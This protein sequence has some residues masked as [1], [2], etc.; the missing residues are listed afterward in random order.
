MVGSPAL[1]SK[2]KPMDD[3]ELAKNASIIPFQAAGGRRSMFTEEAIRLSEDISRNILLFLQKAPVHLNTS[4]DVKFLVG[5]IEKCSEDLL[6]LAAEN[7]SMIVKVADVSL[8]A[9]DEVNEVARN[10][11]QDLFVGLS[12]QHRKVLYIK[13]MEASILHIK[14]RIDVVFSNHL[15]LYLDIFENSLLILVRKLESISS[16]QT[17]MKLMGALESL[18]D[19]KTVRICN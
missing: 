10:I 15:L 8:V 14:E 5:T 4:V 16:V 17:D 2:L 11:N 18:L 3:V 7:Q 6:Q 19:P 9:L 1:L 12:L 13:K